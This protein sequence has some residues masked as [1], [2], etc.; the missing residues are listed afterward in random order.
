MNANKPVSIIFSV[1]GFAA[2]L[3]GSVGQPAARAD[4]GYRYDHRDRIETD[5]RILREDEDHLH[6][7]ER[8]L[9]DQTLNHDFHAARDTRRE[10]DRTRADIDRDRRNLDRDYDHHD[11][12]HNHE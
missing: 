6:H 2:L 4:D 9:D 10:M 1:I 3:V 12:Y 5:R 7:L 8:R 11:G